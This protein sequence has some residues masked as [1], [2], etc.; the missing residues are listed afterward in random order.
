M[1]YGG[2][3]AVLYVATG[4]LSFVVIGLLAFAIG[5]WYLG[6]HI[7]HVH[8]RVEDWLH[9]FN[10]T[11]YNARSAATSSPTRSSPKRQA[12]CSAKGSARPC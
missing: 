3:L 1:F 7:P 8:A 11:L 12:G 9:P 6:T 4:R 10:P 5:A 2:L